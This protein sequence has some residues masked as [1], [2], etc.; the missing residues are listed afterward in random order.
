MTPGS[1]VELEILLIDDDA[2]TNF[3]HR[4]AIHKANRAAVVREVTDGAEALELLRAREA[5]GEPLP[6]FI[7]LDIN[8]PRLDGWG[9]LTA[10][11]QLPA[12]WRRGARLFML[13]TSLNPDDHERAD[14]FTDVRG[15]LDKILS[16]ERFGELMEL[17][18]KEEPLR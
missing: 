14:R 10:Y 17:E 6:N 11:E 16:P 13:T 18:P 1:N 9:F 5:A 15:V 8:M 7:F 4:R 12:A 2:T 3:L